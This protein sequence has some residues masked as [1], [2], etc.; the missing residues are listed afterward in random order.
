V[1][2]AA[3]R[4]LIPYSSF[5]HTLVL[6]RRMREAAHILGSVVC[7]YSGPRNLWRLLLL[8]QW[9]ESQK[10]HPVVY[11]LTGATVV[12]CSYDRPRPPFRRIEDASV[13]VPG[14]RFMPQPNRYIGIAVSYPQLSTNRVRRS[15]YPGINPGEHSIGPLCTQ[16]LSL[17]CLTMAG[18]KDL[19][20][21][22]LLPLG[23]GAGRIAFKRTIGTNDVGGCDSGQHMRPDLSMRRHAKL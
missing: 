11:D 18:C 20:G 8:L 3:R 12:C 19:D 2:R 23:N 4:T 13:V 17:S 9:V 22:R 7:C 21:H 10:H 15:W 16:A 1:Y 14:A 5:L 6:T